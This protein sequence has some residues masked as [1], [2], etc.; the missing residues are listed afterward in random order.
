MHGSNKNAMKQRDIM[1]ALG[2]EDNEPTQGEN[3][4]TNLTDH[5]DEDQVAIT[6]NAARLEEARELISKTFFNLKK[7]K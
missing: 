5:T 6:E 4:D 2:K 7:V 3:T 1:L